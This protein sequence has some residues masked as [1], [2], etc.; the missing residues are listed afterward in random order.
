MRRGPLWVAA[1]VVQSLA[2]AALGAR[3]SHEGVYVNLPH[4]SELRLYVDPAEDVAGATITVSSLHHRTLAEVQACDSPGYSSLEACEQVDLADTWENVSY[5]VS[6]QDRHPDGGVVVPGHLWDTLRAPSSVASLRSIVVGWQ[7]PAM[8]HRERWWVGHV[9]LPNKE[10]PRWPI[11]PGEYVSRDG[12]PNKAPVTPWDGYDVPRLSGMMSDP[13]MAPS[14]SVHTMPHAYWSRGVTIRVRTQGPPVPI[15]APVQGRIVWSGV[16]RRSMPPFLGHE[17]GVNDEFVYAVQL[18]DAWGFVHQLLGFDDQL[19]VAHVGMDVLPGQVLGH[20]PT[21][22]LSA[23]PPSTQ[24]PADIPKRYEEEGFQPYPFRFRRLE[25]RVARP[26]PWWHGDVSHPNAEGWS[27]MHPLLVYHPGRSRPSQMAPLYDPHPV[28]YASM[29]KNRSSALVLDARKKA[30]LLPTHVELLV[31]FPTFMESPSDLDDAM[32]P[33]TLYALEWAVAPVA[34][35]EALC[36]STNVYWRRSFEHSKL[37]RR[38][39]RL[40][41]P[42]FLFAHYVPHVRLGPPVHAKPRSQF[43]EK[44]RSIVYAITRTWLGVPTVH[45]MW[46]TSQESHSG[47]YRLAVRARGVTGPATCVEDMVRIEHGT[48]QHRG[49]IHTIQRLWRDCATAMPWP[50]AFVS[51]VQGLVSWAGRLRHLLWHA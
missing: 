11:G 5:T 19:P 44:S 51:I 24:P 6:A 30:P 35:T 34:E 49:L 14:T 33:L 40:D 28:L 27:Y 16:F 26:P 42:A 13:F 47:L 20:A 22:P 1:A 2:S 12:L 10:R 41:D 18:Q 15:R 32:D 36:T 43:D 38:A 45:G 8:A 29:D 46:N 39:G 50:Y 7:T 31:R 37:E 23:I 25:I 17:A 4:P 3:L 21:Q 48:N 9:V